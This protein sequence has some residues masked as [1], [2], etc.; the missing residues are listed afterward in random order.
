MKKYTWDT[1]THFKLAPLA[2][3]LDPPLP[4]TSSN[5]NNICDAAHE[6]V[7]NRRNGII[8]MGV[9]RTYKGIKQNRNHS[10]IPS[11]FQDIEF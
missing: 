2:D 1:G 10:E 5:Y 9:Q 3:C 6:K 8:S 11:T 4:G 7:P